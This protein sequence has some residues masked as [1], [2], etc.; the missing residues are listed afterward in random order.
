MRLGFHFLTNA[1]STIIVQAPPGLGA[2][3][4]LS[5]ALPSL[6]YEGF[7]SG[8][9]TVPADPVCPESVRSWDA[10]VQD[11]REY[12]FSNTIRMDHKPNFITTL[13]RN[14]A[15]VSQNFNHNVIFPLSNFFERTGFGQGLDFCPQVRLII[16]IV[17]YVVMKNHTKL[18]PIKIKHG[19]HFAFDDLVTRYNEDSSRNTT[20]RG[21]RHS[22][23]QKAILQVFGYLVRGQFR[24]GSLST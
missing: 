14:E 12:R 4:Y 18:F 19:T 17:D 1:N 22:P 7:I 11:A 15:G 21:P 13:V 5:F 20:P 6:T 24:Y 3:E 16:S 8:T 23:V 9:A 2:G 10:F